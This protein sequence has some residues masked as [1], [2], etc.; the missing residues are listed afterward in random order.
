MFGRIGHGLTG[1][2]SKCSQ[3]VGSIVEWPII[4]ELMTSG[5][6]RLCQW[7]VEARFSHQIVAIPSQTKCGQLAEIQSGV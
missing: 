2:A 6:T 4:T 7:K 1:C 3:W 5:M